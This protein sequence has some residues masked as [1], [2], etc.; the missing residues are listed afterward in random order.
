MTGAPRPAAAAF[1]HLLVDD[2]WYTRTAYLPAG[3]LEPAL[4]GPRWLAPLLTDVSPGGGAHHLHPHHPGPGRRGRA[5]RA[6]ADKTSDTAVAMKNTARGKVD[7][8]TDRELLSASARR[9]ADLAPG[10]RHAGIAWG[11]FLTVQARATTSC[12]TPATGCPPRRASAAS[13]AG[14]GATSTRTPPGPPPCR[15]PADCAHDHRT[16]AAHATERRR[17]SRVGRR[18]AVGVV[19]GLTVVVGVVLAAV[20][21]SVLTA[22]IVTEQTSRTPPCRRSRPQRRR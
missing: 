2:A 8:G 6:V 15:W 4:L 20:F 22:S 12:S 16:A 21:A 5:R 10:S 9:L 18:L 1:D 14:S 19:A 11:L 13:P 3:G 7:D 17:R